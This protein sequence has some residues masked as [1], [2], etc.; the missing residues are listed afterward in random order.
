MRL[1]GLP[2]Y[3]FCAIFALTGDALLGGE[4]KSQTRTFQVAIDGKPAGTYQMDIR[5]H[6]DGT[7]TMIGNASVATKYLVFSYSYSY[8]GT[9]KWQ[10][11]RLLDLSS[12]SNDDGKKFEVHAGPHPQNG[13]L[14]V[15]VNNA[16]SQVRPDVW[17]TTYWRLASPAFRGKSVPL[18][19]A[20]TGKYMEGTLQYLGIQSIDVLG[21]TLECAHYHLTGGGGALN[22]HLWYDG[23]ERLVREESVENRHRYTLTLTALK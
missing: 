7:Q 21:Q 13:W 12:S 19:D 22:V 20:D 10:N 11:D 6:E 23:T 4:P 1:P 16:E 5:T 8:A 9:E 18:L 2:V 17:T 3:A 14:S 15:R